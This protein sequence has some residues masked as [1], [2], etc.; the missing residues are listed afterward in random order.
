MKIYRIIL[1][2]DAFDDI[3]HILHYIAKDQGSPLNAERWCKKVLK[4]IYS[5]EKMPERCPYAPENNESDLTIR[6]LRIDSCLFLY[7]IVEKTNT[8]EILRVRHGSRQPY[9]ID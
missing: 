9:R 2:D 8:V 7:C 4:E 6:M 1:S 5:L 3:E